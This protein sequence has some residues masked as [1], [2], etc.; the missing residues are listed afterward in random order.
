VTAWFGRLGAL[1]RSSS[2]AELLPEGARPDLL[3]PESSPAEKL[4]GKATNL[5]GAGLAALAL[6]AGGW[7]GWPE[8]SD[9][10]EEE[11]RRRR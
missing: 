5:T 7:N 6:S 9:D 8:T 1:D 11:R 3:F 10:R 4:E 2:V